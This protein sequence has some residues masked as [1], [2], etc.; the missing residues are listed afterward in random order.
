[1]VLLRLPY[2]FLGW[3]LWLSQGLPMVLLT[4]CELSGFTDNSL[5]VFLWFSKALLRVFLGSFLV[6]LWSSSPF[7]SMP[8]F[9]TASCSHG[10]GTR[11][12]SVTTSFVLLVFNSTMPRGVLGWTSFHT[13]WTGFPTHNNKL[14][15][16]L[17][18]IECVSLR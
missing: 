13:T 11:R 8:A 3:F 17:Y 10:T 5:L 2:S 14:L 12:D 15:K 6:C 1:M 4:F 16:H 18:Q 7:L 9:T